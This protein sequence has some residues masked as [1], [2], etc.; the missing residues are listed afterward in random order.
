MFVY[1]VGSTAG[2][3]RSTRSGRPGGADH[4]AVSAEA[5]TAAAMGA[6]SVVGGAGRVR[7]L[8]AIRRAVQCVQ[9]TG[10]RAALH[11]ARPTA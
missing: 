3:I 1:I 10:R 9:H 7:G 6:A 4:R 11:A 2:I 8:H 5:R